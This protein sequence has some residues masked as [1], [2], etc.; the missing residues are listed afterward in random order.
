[1]Y[2]LVRRLAAVTL[3]AA[4]GLASAGCMGG[5]SPPEA[6][7]S[8]P[9]GDDPVDLDPAD[10]TTEIDNPYWPMVP[11]TR[12]I[13]RESGAESDLTVIVTVTSETKE[14]ANGIRARVVR[15]TV[16]RGDELVEDTFDWYAQDG[17]GAIWYLG[18]D[19]AEFENGAIVSREGSFEAGV[20]G[21]LPGVAIP[22]D[23]AARHDVSAGIPQGRG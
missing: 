1:M 23:P 13:Y 19:T 11:G 6:G 18:E 4:V 7:R 10:F 5:D 22:A 2:R 17:S 20:D 8:L 15:D 16:W 14:I 12:W 21:A 9:Q 3:I